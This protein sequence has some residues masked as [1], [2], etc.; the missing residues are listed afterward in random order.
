MFTRALFNVYTYEEVD[1][2]ANGAAYKKLQ[3]VGGAYTPPCAIGLPTRGGV[4]MP[5]T[6]VTGDGVKLKRVPNEV[7]RDQNGLKRLLQE[8]TKRNREQ[9]RKRLTGDEIE[10]LV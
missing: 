8:Q 9:A 1:A 10:A 4:V 3:V 5:G 7:T 6:F 2:N